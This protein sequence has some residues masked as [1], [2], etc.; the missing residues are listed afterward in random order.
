M[1][2]FI[3][4]ENFSS[5]QLLQEAE[6]LVIQMDYERALIFYQEAFQKYPK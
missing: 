6:K 5:D 3:A 1:S 2:Q 4:I